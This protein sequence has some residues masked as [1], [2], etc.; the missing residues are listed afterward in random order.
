MLLF[1]VFQDLPELFGRRADEI[2]CEIGHP[3]Q[4]E[5]YC[6]PLRTSFDCLA[7]IGQRVPGFVVDLVARDH[8]RVGYVPQV[9]PV[10]AVTRIAVTPFPE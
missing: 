2:V 9:R 6:A 4:A 10:A 5:N 1:Q 8:H 3:V 7:D